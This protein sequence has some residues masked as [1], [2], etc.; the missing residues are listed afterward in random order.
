MKKILP[1]LIIFFASLTG[2]AQQKP[3]YTQY[4]LNNILLNPAVT[5]IENYIDLKAAY[6]SQWIGLDGAPT[7]SVLTLSA[8]IGNA[9]VSGDAVSMS[10]GS[11]NPYSP[12]YAQNYQS[13]PPHHGIGFT[14]VSDR[15]GYTKTTNID[16]T[17]AYHLGLSSDLNL[18]LGIS[19]GF[20]NTSLNTSAITVQQPDDNV[21][22]NLQNNSWS[23]DIGIGIWAYSAD[24]YIGLSALQL[25]PRH[26]A[27]TTTNAQVQQNRLSPNFFAT[28]GLKLSLSEDVAVVPSILFKMISNLPPAFDANTKMVFDGRFW[29]GGSY[30]Y[31]DAIGGMFG[32]NINSLV[33]VSY[34][35]DR[36]TSALQAVSPS[37]HEIVIGLMLNNRGKVICPRHSF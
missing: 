18:S 16:A 2:R 23:P 33:N 25:L 37:T 17:Y 12:A 7:T 32:L 15:L 5:G 14:L 28:A 6:R 36:A 20:N 31:R 3:Q 9:F 27:L 26:Y 30:R 1:V 19:A 11:D 35:Y 10:P 34:S 22:N 24:Y 8:P 29:I 4:I 21:I 13:A